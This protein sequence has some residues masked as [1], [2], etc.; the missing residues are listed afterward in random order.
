[1]K[2]C[3]RT[4]PTSY[5]TRT[6]GRL[7]VAQERGTMAAADITGPL[8]RE[9]EHH[10]LKHGFV[11]APSNF[12]TAEEKALFIKSTDEM[13]DWPEKKG[14]YMKYYESKDGNRLLCRIENYIDYCDPKLKDLI[15][16][17]MNA[18]C[19][20]LLNEETI[21]FKEKVNFKLAGAQGFLPHQGKLRDG[22]Q[23]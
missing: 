22:W 20:Q 1:M 11:R 12:L 6:V 16:G 2:K 21:M 18:A 7:V 17:R 15:V 14:E 19:Q 23:G 10:F 8:S 9:N 13:Q 3:E 5:S 4:T